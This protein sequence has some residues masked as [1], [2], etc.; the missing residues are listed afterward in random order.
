[1]SA[2]CN[3]SCNYGFLHMYYKKPYTCEIGKWTYSERPCGIHMRRKIFIIIF[4][5]YNFLKSSRW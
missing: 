2:S 5:K 1:M 3:L 4:K